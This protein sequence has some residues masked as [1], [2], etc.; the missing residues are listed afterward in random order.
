MYG[1][2][3]RISSHKGKSNMRLIWL[4]LILL[5]VASDGLRAEELLQRAY[6]DRADTSTDAQVHVIYA[7]PAGA[8]DRRLD[9]LGIIERSLGVA[10]SWLAEATGGQRLR[11]DRTAD[12]HLDIS[13]LQ[14]ARDAET[15]RG[16]GGH[17]RDEIEKDINAAGFNHPR[18]IYLVYFE[19]KNKRT[20]ASGAWP[21]SLPGNAAVLFLLTTFSKAPPCTRYWFTWEEPGWWEN[22]AVHELLHTL[23]FAARCGQAGVEGSHVLDDSKD[24][25]YGRS[26]KRG[27]RFLDVD[28]GQYYRHG[29]EGCPDLA[30]SAFL[31]PSSS[32][33]ELPPGWVPDKHCIYSGYGKRTCRDITG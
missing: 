7:L 25:L 17:I 20:C 22:S 21:P 12:G 5:L 16:F 30:N 14:L 10:N 2:S 27:E 19:G 3:Y 15:Y 23:G 1:S 31:E 4:T 18:K 28:H 11:Y 26:R 6:E 33:A 29:I 13:F 8:Y 9:V 24:L 32:P